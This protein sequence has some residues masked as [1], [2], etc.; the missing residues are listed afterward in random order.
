[1]MKFKTQKL[2]FS[3]KEESFYL[4][5][6]LHEAWKYQGLTYPNPAVG[7]VILGKNLEILAINAHKKAGDAHSELGAVKIA[8]SKLNPKL[9][10]P[11][12]PNDLHQFILKHHDNLLKDSTFFVTL[13]PCS[14]IGKTPSCAYLLKELKPK[15]VFVGLKDLNDIASGGIKILKSGGIEVIKSTLSNKCHE[16]L[17]PFLMWQKG[18][19]SFFKLALSS[20][21]V[22][23]GG[24]ISCEKSREL[25]H[26]LR[27]RCD[28]LLIGGNSVR[29][30]RPILDA[31][32][33][34]GKAPDILIYS[35]KGNFDK[36]IPLFHIKNRKVF[37][38]NSFKRLNDYNFT[39]IEGG[40]GM[41]R[42]LPE[43]ISHFL[44]FHSP[45]FIDG[46]NI[47][48]DLNLKLLWQGKIGKDS[49]GWYK[50]VNK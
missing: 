25:V 29:V 39:M 27:D 14:H 24:I 20:N 3:G 42:A 38:D 36:D 13:E 49:Y 47:K 16:L 40:E 21:G 23:K 32:L 48:I 26:K 9:I 17:E 4:S 50:R 43:Q 1:M 46:Q 33:C 30:D 11:K 45:D 37:I 44:L 22:I 5:L 7:T 6:A 15:Y 2:M 10:F 34:N 31:R 19:F 12:N 18:N 41:L 8:L 28:S 35:K